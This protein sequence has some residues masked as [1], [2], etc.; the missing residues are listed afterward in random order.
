M[1][2]I[3]VPPNETRYC[4]ICK[5]RVLAGEQYVQ[6]P[7]HKYIGRHVTCQPKSD[8]D[9]NYKKNNN[10]DEDVI[11]KKLRPKLLGSDQRRRAGGHGYS[12]GDGFVDIRD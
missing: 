10:L 11:R 9:E 5:N 4:I 8:W 12:G 7:G 2:T 1:I 3:I 6:V